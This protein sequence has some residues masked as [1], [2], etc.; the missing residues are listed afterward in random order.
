MENV[1]W[2]KTNENLSGKFKTF[3]S[4]FAAEVEMKIEFAQKKKLN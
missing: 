3:F 2:V 4:R 1:Q